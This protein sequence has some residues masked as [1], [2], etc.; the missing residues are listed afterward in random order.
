MKVFGDE[1][2]LRFSTIS[3]GMIIIKSNV[4]FIEKKCKMLV[5]SMCKLISPSSLNLRFAYFYMQSFFI[6][7]CS[8]L[9]VV[10]FD[11]FSLLFL[12]SNI[13]LKFYQCISKNW[14]INT[15]QC[16]ID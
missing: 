3:L 15:I 2:T 11:E 6:T 7:R 13:I 9:H 5:Q 8:K 14:R 16:S 12:P 1:T 10:D 4:L